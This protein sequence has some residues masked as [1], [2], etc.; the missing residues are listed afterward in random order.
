MVG[1]IVTSDLLEMAFN[2]NRFGLSHSRFA[3][4]TDR[5][6]ALCALDIPEA[7]NYPESDLIYI[8]AAFYLIS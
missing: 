1:L 3:A 6:T 4:S 8:A 7:A 5:K 2:V